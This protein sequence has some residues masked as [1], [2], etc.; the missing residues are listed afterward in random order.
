M[1]EIQTDVLV[2]GGG[3]LGI[4]VSYWLSKLT[5]LKLALIDENEKLASGTSGT[6]SF[7][8]QSPLFYDPNSVQKVFGKAICSSRKFW[9]KFS[10]VAKIKTLGTLEIA[11][12]E[13][14]LKVIETHYSWNAYY[15][16]HEKFRMLSKEEVRKLEPNLLSSG[17]LLLEEDGTADYA[18]A[19]IEM[20]NRSRSLN[21]IKGQRVSKI[22]EKE[23]HVE[24][25]SEDFKIKAS[26]LLNATGPA[27]LQLA[28]KMGLAKDY[29]DVYIGSYYWKTEPIFN[30]H[31][32]A[33]SKNASTK[34]PYLYPYLS[35]LFDGTRE[36]GPKPF[37]IDSPFYRKYGS[38]KA[39]IKSMFSRPLLPKLK[40]L[41][42]KEF[43]NIIFFAGGAFVSENYVINKA[44]EYIPALKLLNN[45]RL[46][47]KRSI[48]IGPEGFI[49]PSTLIKTQRTMHVLQYYEPGVTGTPAFSH[50]LAVYIAKMLGIK[51][52]ET[53]EIEAIPI[54]DLK[55]LIMNAKS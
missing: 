39:A 50:A 33:I 26:F 37:L 21:I 29:A 6:N 47:G 54:D 5:N 41:F 8:I 2:V 17:G 35:V 38:R 4:S 30:H 3:A 42:D 32:F 22:I 36:V 25:F 16:P 46:A 45:K 11:V 18:S 44:R 48:I 31:V 12:Q 28:H 24:A 14:M 10:E 1:N 13:E 53:D 43:F 40:L 55:P 34:F 27:A 49:E 15:C 7:M 19:L 23:D 20:S 51:I 52:E 9:K